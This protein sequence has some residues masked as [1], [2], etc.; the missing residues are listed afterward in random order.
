MRKGQEKLIK[1]AEELLPKEF[2]EKLMDESFTIKKLELLF[3]WMLLFKDCP[4]IL[5]DWDTFCQDAF[6]LKHVYAITGDWQRTH[7]LTS[8]KNFMAAGI[9]SW[10]ITGRHLLTGYILRKRMISTY[11]TRMI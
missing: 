6:S 4:E 7:V 1:R 9:M 3:R 5:D 11:S 8:K 10:M 2:V